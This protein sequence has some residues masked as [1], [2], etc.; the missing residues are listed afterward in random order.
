[1]SMYELSLLAVIAPLA[2]A[3]IVGLFGWALSETQAHRIAIAGVAI[4][5]IASAVIF[6]ELYLSYFDPQIFEVYQWALIGEFSLGIGFLIDSLTAIMMI[7]VT[8][9][10][11]MVHIYTIG[12][13]HGDPGYKRF[14][15]YISLFTFA[16]LM[17]VMSRVTK[18]PTPIGTVIDRP[19][20]AWIAMRCTS[21]CAKTWDTRVPP[22]PDSSSAVR[23]TSR[24][25]AIRGCGG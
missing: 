25:A 3:I 20:R 11:L 15:S 22:P 7:V 4:A 6:Y 18:S 16:M 13:M 9:V 19:S 21:S 14:F 5:F 17:L 10:S 1:M 23:R 2:G 24:R 8:F 12:Y